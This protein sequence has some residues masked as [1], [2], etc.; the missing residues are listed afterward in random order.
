MLGSWWEA[1]K[2]LDKKSKGY[3]V[4]KEYFAAKRNKKNTS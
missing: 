4:G 2:I 1:R 3:Q